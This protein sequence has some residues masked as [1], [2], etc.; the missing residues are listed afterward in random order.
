MADNMNPIDMTLAVAHP[1]R[2]WWMGPQAQER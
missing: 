2:G 1:A